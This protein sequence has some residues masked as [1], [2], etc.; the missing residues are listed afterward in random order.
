MSDSIPNGSGDLSDNQWLC[1][2]CKA[3]VTGHIKVHWLIRW[4]DF[5]MRHICPHCG[6]RYDSN[7][8][9]ADRAAVAAARKSPEKPEK[10]TKREEARRPRAWKRQ[11]AGRR[12]RKVKRELQMTLKRLAKASVDELGKEARQLYLQKVID[13][14]L[15]ESALTVEAASIASLMDELVIEVAGTPAQKI[16]ERMRATANKAKDTPGMRMT[17]IELDRCLDSIKRRSVSAGK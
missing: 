5:V 7:P 8:T 17:R 1:P 3:S 15:L 9:D 11:V 2:K 4:G 10:K 16:A 13:E 12:K 6:K 14:H